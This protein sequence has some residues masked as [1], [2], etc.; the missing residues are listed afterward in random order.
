MY[1]LTDGAEYPLLCCTTLAS[2]GLDELFT[3]RSLWD[4]FCSSLIW[5]KRKSVWLTFS[6]HF[7]ML[8]KCCVLNIKRM[9]TCTFFACPVAHMAEVNFGPS[10]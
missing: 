2:S 3:I 4:L 10:K 6:L 1:N 5:V 7:K 9:T 8:F